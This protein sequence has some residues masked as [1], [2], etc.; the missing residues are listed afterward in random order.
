MQLTHKSKSHIDLNPNNVLINFC[1]Q[2]NEHLFF[3][4]GLVIQNG[5]LIGHVKV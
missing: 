4:M 2:N 3:Q 1:K 5:I